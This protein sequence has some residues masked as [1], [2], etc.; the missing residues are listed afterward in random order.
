[1]S[2]SRRSANSE[3]LFFE[4]Q[5]SRLGIRKQANPRRFAFKPEYDERA[6]QDMALTI[7]KASAEEVAIALSPSRHVPLAKSTSTANARMSLGRTRL[8]ARGHHLAENAAYDG[9]PDPSL[10]E[11]KLALTF[12]PTITIVDDEIAARHLSQLPV[13][14]QK[15]LAENTFEIP[16]QPL[17]YVN[18]IHTSYIRR[19]MKN[20]IGS[21]LTRAEMQKLVSQLLLCERNGVEQW[22]TNEK[23]TCRIQRQF[24]ECY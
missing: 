19:R 21:I 2:R 1:M 14:R 13:E 6:R 3:N 11:A 7:A 20:R 15:Y 16:T 12:K 10:Q 4:N 17:L 9:I 23:Y 8:M 22:W 24:E 18:S 5:M